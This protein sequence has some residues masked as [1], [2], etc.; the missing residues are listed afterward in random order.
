MAAGGYSLD[1]V[2]F[3][4]KRTRTAPV[5]RFRPKEEPQDQSQGKEEKDC[6]YDQGRRLPAAPRI[7]GAK[8]DCSDNQPKDGGSEN[9]ENC[10][11]RS[12]LHLVRFVKI[13][14]IGVS[15]LEGR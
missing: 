7:F 9:Q 12:V 15:W 8:S 1:P 11:I 2:I 6:E 13:P 10:N 14:N 5:D 4:A 3:K